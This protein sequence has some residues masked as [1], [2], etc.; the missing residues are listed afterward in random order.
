MESHGGA[1]AVAF[2]YAILVALAEIKKKV[3]QRIGRRLASMHPQ[4]VSRVKYSADIG[5]GGCL[6][7]AKIMT[8]ADL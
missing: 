2:E 1:D 4:G 5:T 6:C 8:N 7:R 3:P